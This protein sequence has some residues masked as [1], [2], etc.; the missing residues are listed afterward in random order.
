M[1]EQGNKYNIPHLKV[2]L[3]ASFSEMI[4]ANK[5]VFN[6]TMNVLHPSLLKLFALSICNGSCEK[7]SPEIFLLKNVQPNAFQVATMMALWKII[8]MFCFSSW[9]FSSPHYVAY[10]VCQRLQK[11]M[12]KVNLKVLFCKIS[13]QNIRFCGFKK[14]TFVSNERKI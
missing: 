10:L 14:E 12:E 4:W 13:W 7:L 5:K 1:P 3:E 6:C 8:T 9:N 11:F 2:S